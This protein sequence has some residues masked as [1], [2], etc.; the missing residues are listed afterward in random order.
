MCKHPVRTVRGLTYEE[1]YGPITW[2]NSAGS[3]LPMEGH[4]I[5]TL[6]FFGLNATL[7]F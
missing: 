6:A 4:S 7:L 3:Q 2:T 1:L 5:E